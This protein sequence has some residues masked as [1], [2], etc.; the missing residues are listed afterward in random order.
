[1]FDIRIRPDGLHQASGALGA[2]SAHVGERSGHWLDG[3]LIAAGAYPEW[4]AGPALQECAQA[5]QT[6]MTSVV[7]QLQTYSEQLR[8]SAHSYDA[9]NEEAG[10]RFDQ[11]AR[12]LNAGA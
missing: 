7:Q 5:W 8:D 9:A 11:A 12:D 4:A 2:T 3:S 10:R 6:H 1:M